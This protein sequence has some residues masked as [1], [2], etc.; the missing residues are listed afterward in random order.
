MGFVFTAAI[1]F[2][3]GLLFGAAITEDCKKSDAN[4]EIDS[5]NSRAMAYL[6]SLK[7]TQGQ[8][9]QVTEKAE[10]INRTLKCKIKDIASQ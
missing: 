7:K 5:L 10:A 2:L 4:T 1:A 8:I 9:G 3:L 6:E